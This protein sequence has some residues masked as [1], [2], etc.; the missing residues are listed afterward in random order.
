[1]DPIPEPRIDKIYLKGGI[2]VVIAVGLMIG[3]L[4]DV[5]ETR[6]WFYVALPIGLV[7]AAI[8]M[9]RHRGQL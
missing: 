6:L 5:P 2:G 3:F 9:W 8:L 4:A 7:V 1:M